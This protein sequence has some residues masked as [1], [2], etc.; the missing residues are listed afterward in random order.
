MEVDV[1]GRVFL[2]YVQ[3]RE[4]QTWSIKPITPN[5]TW[6]ICKSRDIRRYWALRR[7]RKITTE[8][9]T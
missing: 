3:E 7:R 5:T 8:E 6:H 2:A 9:G 1:K 4:G